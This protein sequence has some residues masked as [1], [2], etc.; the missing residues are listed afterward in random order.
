MANLNKILNLIKKT[1]DKVVLVNESDDFSAVIMPF[2][3]YEKMIDSQD[4]VRKLSE[5]ELLGKIN[6]DIAI[7]K[8]YQDNEENEIAFYDSLEKTDVKDDF[9][10][11][12]SGQLMEDD[13]RLETDDIDDWASVAELEE[14]ELVDF[15]PSLENDDNKKI[16]YEDIPPPPDIMS[17]IGSYEGKNKPIIDLGLEDEEL[18]RFDGG[19]FINENNVE[20]LTEEDN[21]DEWQTEFEEEPVF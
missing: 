16:K 8:E 19:N 1:G 5:N 14:S 2:F 7:W 12:N 6:R 21:D 18:E 9:D 11:L 4:N 20:D 3:E 15:E 10:W 17:Q 13:E